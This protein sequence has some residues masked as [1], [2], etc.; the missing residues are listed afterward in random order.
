MLNLKANVYILHVY[1]P[2]LRSKVLNDRDFDFYDKIEKGIKKYSQTYITDDL[3]SRC[4]DLSDTLYV[5]RYLYHVTE[6]NI[7][8]GNLPVRH[9]QDKVADIN[10]RRLILL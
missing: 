10:G 3:N 2:L 5:D 7:S 6:K 1:I 8:I 4:A 9:S